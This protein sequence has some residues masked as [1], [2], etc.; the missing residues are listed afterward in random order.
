MVG[1]LL[2][3]IIPVVCTHNHLTFAVSDGR[4]WK[5]GMNA[6]VVVPVH[7]KQFVHLHKIILS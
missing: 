7:D 4:M 3:P 1:T 6:T 5:S 2:A